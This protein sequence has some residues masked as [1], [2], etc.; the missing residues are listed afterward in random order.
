MRDVDLIEAAKAGDEHAFEMLHA[1]HAPWARAVALRF[2]PDEHAASDA[3]QEAFLDLWTRLPTFTLTA[4]FR[5][6]LYPVVKH[7]A[8]SRRRKELREP[9]L[10]A[11]TREAAPE[12]GPL[13][14]ALRLL[15]ETQREVLVMRAVDEMSLDEIATALDIPVG[16]VKSRLHHAL[17]KIREDERLRR[18]Y[19]P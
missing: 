15:P 10:P 3:V 12:A 16:T 8:L 1:R 13:L 14:E 19:F 11:M 2:A 18:R 9:P 4:A 17:A 7:A 6:W 5:S